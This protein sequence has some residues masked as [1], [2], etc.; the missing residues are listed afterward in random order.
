M[1]Q[2]NEIKQNLDLEKQNAL[3][4]LIKQQEDDDYSIINKGSLYVKDSY[5][6]IFYISYQYLI[7]KHEKSGLESVKGPNAF[8]EY[9]NKMQDFYKNIEDY[10]SSSACIELIVFDDMIA[11]LIS[12]KTFSQIVTKLFIRGKK[13]NASTVF[14]TECSFQIPKDVRINSF[15]L[16]YYENSKQSRALTNYI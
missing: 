8:I 4:N 3:L 9:L 7:K 10:S 11:D 5:E 6:A 14:I 13:V 1:Y 12:N 2:H 15:K 16:F